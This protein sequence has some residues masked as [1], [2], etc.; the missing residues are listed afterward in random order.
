MLE[1]T[2]LGQKVHLQQIPRHSNIKSNDDADRLANEGRG[3]EQRVHQNEL[4]DINKEID[5]IAHQRWQNMWD[6]DKA[7]C[8]FGT[9]KEHVGDWFWTRHRSR[10]LDVCMTQLRL[11]CARLNKYLFKIKAVNTSICESCSLQEYESVSHY[12]LRCPAFSIQRAT[13]EGKLRKYGFV[14]IDIPVL[15]GAADKVNSKKKAITRDLAFFIKTTGRMTRQK[16]CLDV[17]QPSLKGVQIVIKDYKEHI[18]F[19]Q[20]L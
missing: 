2:R 15:L 16:Y 18:T 14:D 9:L 7:Y 20:L 5:R 3:C 17:P 6:M 13:L 10:T 4:K 11:R 1:L 8:S 12:L 19:L